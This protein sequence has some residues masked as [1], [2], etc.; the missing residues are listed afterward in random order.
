MSILF[1]DDALVS[2]VHDTTYDDKP[3]AIFFDSTGC[4]TEIIFNRRIST[5]EQMLQIANDI[6]KECV[7]PS[8][9]TVDFP[10]DKLL[11]P[12]TKE[13]HTST[14][15]PAHKIEVATACDLCPNVC[16]L[17]ISMTEDAKLLQ[18]SGNRCP[19]GIE[20]AKK[21]VE[22]HRYKSH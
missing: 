20:Y 14:M 6:L 9:A 12:Q 2:F 11:A 13:T 1:T 16:E 19:R 7:F 5:S 3:L 18:V 17:V 4:I 22:G 21:Y 10:K 8:M 15:V